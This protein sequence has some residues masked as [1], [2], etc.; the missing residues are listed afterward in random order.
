MNQGCGALA[1]ARYVKVPL[2]IASVLPL[3][4]AW[5]EAEYKGGLIFIDALVFV[6]AAQLLM[7]LEMDRHDLL[8]GIAPIN[9]DSFITTGPCEYRCGGM[10]ALRAVAGLLALA[11]ALAAILITKSVTL[12]LVGVAAIVI[13]AAYLLK[14]LELYKRGLGEI[15]TFMDFGPLLVYGSL[16]AF[17]A[18]WGY[19]QAVA[20]IIFGLDASL[21]RFRHHLK[22][23]SGFRRRHARE[24]TSAFIALILTLALIH[25][26]YSALILVPSTAGYALSLDGKDEDEATLA[27]YIA[28][29]SSIFIF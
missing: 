9:C 22:E 29:A 17:G 14:P 18:H 1:V 24:I 15:S 7:N 2:F 16:I 6:L 21:L 26:I 27:Y 5:V 25:S 23:E 13:M 10:G 20:S 3:V 11:T 19:S 28:V 8:R 12:V 4:W